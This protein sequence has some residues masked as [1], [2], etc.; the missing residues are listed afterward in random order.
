MRK[1]LSEKYIQHFTEI[2][3]KKQF[4]SHPPSNL[5]TNYFRIMTLCYA[6]LPRALHMVG[7]LLEH[8]EQNAARELFYFYLKQG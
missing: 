7:Y 1:L 4:T 8:Q 6:E 3:V 2:I 5:I